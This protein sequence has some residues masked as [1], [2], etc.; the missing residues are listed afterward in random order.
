MYNVLLTFLSQLITE[1]V[2]H[3]KPMEHASTLVA[4]RVFSTAVNIKP[5]PDKSTAKLS[6][7]ATQSS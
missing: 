6:W 3:P 1:T 2:P 4:I 7:K 5:K